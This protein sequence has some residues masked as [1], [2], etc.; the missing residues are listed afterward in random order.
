MRT[1][2]VKYDYLSYNE[3]SD[4]GFSKEPAYGGQTDI[5]DGYWVYVYPNWYVYKEK[6]K[7]I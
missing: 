3:F 1:I 4:Y 6:D 7:G 2:N 5:P